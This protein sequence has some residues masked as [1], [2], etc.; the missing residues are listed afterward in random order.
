MKLKLLSLGWVLGV[1]A[2][3]TVPTGAPELDSLLGDYLAALGRSDC[4]YVRNRLLSPTVKQRMEAKKLDEGVLFCRD[5][6]DQL[7]ALV[8]EAKNRGPVVSPSGRSAAYS[9][10][11]QVVQLLFEKVN[12]RWY[13]AN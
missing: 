5:N 11:D 12:G 1:V 4:D 8:Q 3:A 13:L 10:G 7:T 2:C 9:T 6:I